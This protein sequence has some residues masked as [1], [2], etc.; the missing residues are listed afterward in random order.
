VHFLVSPCVLCVH[1]ILRDVVILKI[2]VKNIDYE[3]FLLE[4]LSSSILLRLSQVKLHHRFILKHISWPAVRINNA[5]R[6]QSTSTYTLYFTAINNS[7]MAAFELLR[8][9]R[10]WCMVTPSEMSLVLAATRM[11]TVVFWNI[12]P[13]S[14]IHTDRRFRGTFCHHLSSG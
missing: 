10:L 7:K 12:A 1:L 5:T 9:K 6:R 14:L 8:R 11:K 13:C 3:A 4:N 2:P